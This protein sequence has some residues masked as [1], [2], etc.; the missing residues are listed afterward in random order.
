[1]SLYFIYGVLNSTVLI[2]M[3]TF[4]KSILPLGSVCSLHCRF[5]GNSLLGNAATLVLAEI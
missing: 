2:N 5:S 3:Q 4:C 1:M